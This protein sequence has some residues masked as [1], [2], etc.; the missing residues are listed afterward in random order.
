MSSRANLVKHTFTC[1]KLPLPY[2]VSRGE[3][4]GRDFGTKGGDG[5]EGGRVGEERGG[6]EG[7]EYKKQKRS[8]SL[9]G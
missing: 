2:T 9:K 8:S 4:G 5:G 3:G 1:K 6:R 7:G